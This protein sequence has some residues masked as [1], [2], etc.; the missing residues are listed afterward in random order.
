ML[1]KD[2]DRHHEDLQALREST[3][4]LFSGKGITWPE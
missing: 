4:H 2:V 3:G 1:L